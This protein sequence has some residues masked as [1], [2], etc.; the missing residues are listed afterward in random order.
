[1]ASRVSAVRPHCKST[2]G[3]DVD[4]VTPLSHLSHEPDNSNNECKYLVQLIQRKTV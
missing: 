3:F 1:M 2:E 4:G